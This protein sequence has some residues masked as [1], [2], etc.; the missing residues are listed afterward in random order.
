MSSSTEE[1]FVCRKHRGEILTPGGIVFEDD[2]VSASHQIIEQSEASYPGVLFVEPKR[3]VP[4]LADLNREEAERL[5]WVCSL[6][7][8]ALA[9]EG[10]ARTY[11]AVLGHGVSHLHYWVVPRYPM[12]PDDIRGLRVIDWL[13]GPRQ[14]WDEISALCARLR[15]HISDELV[16]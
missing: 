3:H 10:A 4:T 1:C 6:M 14:G 16:A 15:Q 2:L 9:H 7:S 12:I 13:G 5:G 8:R 11:L